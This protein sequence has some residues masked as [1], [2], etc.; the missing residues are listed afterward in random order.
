MLST[1]SE[2]IPILRLGPDRAGGERMFL[3]GAFQAAG[4]LALIG[5]GASVWGNELL[6]KGKK[7]E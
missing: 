2:N 3:M 6:G 1:M 7:L 5:A 4:T